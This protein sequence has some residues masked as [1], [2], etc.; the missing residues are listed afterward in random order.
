M[1]EKFISFDINIINNLSAR[2]TFCAI[3]R[4]DDSRDVKV[5]QS[6]I[7]YNDKTP[8]YGTV[9]MN[10]YT[11]SHGD[12]T[13]KI[14]FVLYKYNAN[15]DNK[16]IYSETVSM[17]E[18]IEATKQ[19][20]TKNKLCLEDVK[21]LNY[22]FTD[23]LY[24]KFDLNVVFGIDFTASNGDPE[25]PYSLH[26]I[27][28]KHNISPYQIAI[29]SIGNILAS[30]DHDR[31]FDCFGFGSKVVEDE[32]DYKKSSVQIMGDNETQFAF[33]INGNAD[34]PGC[35]GIFDIERN[36]IKLLQDKEKYILSGPTNFGPMLQRVIQIAVEAVKKEENK[37]F[38]FV[39]MTDGQIT[40][41]NETTKLIKDIADK[42]LPVS[43]IIVGI[44]DDDFEN[45]EELD[46]DEDNVGK[47]DVVQF[48]QMNHYIDKLDG[49]IQKD[50]LSRDVLYE[51]PNQLLSYMAITGKEPDLELHGNTNNK[52][53][54]M[55]G[56]YDF[57]DGDK[58]DDEK[59]DHDEELKEEK[60]LIEAEAGEMKIERDTP[61]PFG[62]EKCYDING[63]IFVVDEKGRRVGNAEFFAELIQIIM[64]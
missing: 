59:D 6:K 53:V 27:Y 64:I 32:D 36:Y 57:D 8:K 22:S 50:R 11:L 47:R 39:I 40:D 19:P 14:K 15:K 17:K 49:K 52:T 5:H 12:Y 20:L 37:Y 18:L 63:N 31:T 58:D 13:K 10:T 4:A 34:N 1:K 51:L 35:K 33:A 55:G 3:Y 56:I 26:Y 43:I 28:D 48:V 44:G 41:M 23:Y 7:I 62:W 2:D 29:R 24:D 61:I 25:E 21:T 38:I 60:E 16:V 9:R 42:P 54:N 45:M 30:Y 46:G